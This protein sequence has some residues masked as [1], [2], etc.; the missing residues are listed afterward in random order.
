MKALSLKQP[1]AELVISGRKTIE[2]RKWKTNHRGTFLV[3]ASQSVDK[4][5]MQRFG[6]TTL[7]TGCILGTATLIDVKHYVHEE[8]HKKDSDKHLATSTWGNYGFLLENAKRFDKPIAAKGKL[9]FWNY[10]EKFTK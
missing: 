8:E 10:A 4:E 9:N 3:H 5:A 7:P 2:L 1:Y 6:Y